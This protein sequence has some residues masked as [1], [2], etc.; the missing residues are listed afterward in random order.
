MTFTTLTFLIFFVVVFAL[1]WSL[2]NRRMQNALLIVAG[3]VFYG[4]WDW[5][6]C[7]LMV[8]ASFLDYFLGP[9]LDKPDVPWK[10]NL[11]LTCGL[12]GNL[13][14]LGFFKYFNFFAENFQALAAS[15]GWRVDPIT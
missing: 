4:W 9:G 6:Y 12:A 7:L 3:Y 11:L 14:M 1:Y 15:L 13:A 5:R 8:A 10:R 2:H